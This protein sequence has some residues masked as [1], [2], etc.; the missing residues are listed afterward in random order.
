MKVEEE[1]EGL[2]KLNL[3]A[4]KLPMKGYVNIDINPGPF[5]D[6]V[7]DVRKMKERYQDG[8]VDEIMA[9]DVLEHLGLKCWKPAL[10]DWIDLLK[11]GG[12][13]KMRTP[14]LKESI[15]YF[16]VMA[17]VEG[18]DEEEN[19]NKWL[20]YAYGS[21]DFPANFH[22]CGFT[23]K[24]LTRDLEA[25]GMDVK[26]TWNDGGCQMRVTA[27]KKG[28]EPL[29]CLDHNDYNWEKFQLNLIPK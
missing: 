20:M 15:N 2:L 7:H 3:G 27:V 13:L 14:D 10:Q 21:Q 1:P 28:A 22:N 19:W 6:I 9:C 29:T 18:Y 25:M 12:V 23:S 4:G 17:P 5:I 16:N 11:P 24:W 8:T 26:P